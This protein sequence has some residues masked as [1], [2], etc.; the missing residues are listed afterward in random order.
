M[1]GTPSLK[2]NTIPNGKILG[3]I[4]N[5]TRKRETSQRMLASYFIMETTIGEIALTILTLRT[6]KAKQGT[7]KKKRK[8]KRTE[9]QENK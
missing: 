2:R 8:V 5:L 4:L 6:S 1:K 3:S 7:G 9:G